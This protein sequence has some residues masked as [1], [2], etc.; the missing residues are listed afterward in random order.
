MRNNISHKFMKKYIKNE[1][2][3]VPYVVVVFI[4]LYIITTFAIGHFFKPKTEEAQHNNQKQ[5]VQVGDVQSVTTCPTS[6]TTY[7]Q[8]LSTIQ[9]NYKSQI[10]PVGSI[11]ISVTDSTAAAVAAR[12]GG[13]WEAFSTGKTIVGIDPNDS[14]FDS[15]NDTGGVK[16][17]TITNS[18]LPDHNHIV[19]VTGT[20]ASNGAHTHT[21]TSLHGSLYSDWSG[22]TGSNYKTPS[23]NTYKNVSSPWYAES[24][25][26][27]THTVTL[28]AS[29]TTGC[30][31]CGTTPISVMNPYIVV[32]MWKRVS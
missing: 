26:A 19:N 4:L 3:H 8:R 28:N 30:T 25:G 13:T 10:Y 11:Y 31:D 16:T 29:N 22:T 21:V 5:E 2:K 27:H 23:S 32:Y 7:V 17:A 12:F 24:N 15:L 14:N 1:L 20:A 18:N 9:N 6:N